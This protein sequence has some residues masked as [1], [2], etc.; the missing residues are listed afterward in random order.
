MRSVELDSI[1]DNIKTRSVCVN[2]AIISPMV[3]AYQNCPSNGFR[4]YSQEHDSSDEGEDEHETKHSPPGF[5]LIV[6]SCP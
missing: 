3:S 6:V 4:T 2:R 5:T 1:A